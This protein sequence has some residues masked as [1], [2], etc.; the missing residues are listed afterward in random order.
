MASSYTR[1]RRLDAK[2]ENKQRLQQLV[3]PVGVVYNKKDRAVRTSRVNSIFALIPIQAS[4]FEEKENGDSV[5]NRHKSDLVP[6][7]GIEPVLALLQTG[8]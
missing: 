5:K 4:F 3:F 6:Q 8:F 2:Y 7:T 1:K